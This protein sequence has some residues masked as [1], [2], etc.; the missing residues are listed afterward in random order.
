M[1]EPEA[2]PGNVWIVW[3]WQFDG[4]CCSTS[5]HV[6]AEAGNAPSCGSVA[7]PLKLM[8]SPT[9]HVVPA[10]GVEITGVGGLLPTLMTSL[11]VPVAN[12]ASVT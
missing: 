2:T 3:E 1:N 6:S 5:V 4:Q 8:R 12:P 7:E 11:S 10:V 9:F